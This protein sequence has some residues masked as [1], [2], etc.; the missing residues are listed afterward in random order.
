MSGEIE[1]STGPYYL[2]MG[3][4][5]DFGLEELKDM[6]VNAGLDNI[7]INNIPKITV[8]SGLNDIRLKEFP[9]EPL[10]MDSK[11]DMGLDDIRITQLPKIELET[12]VSI[13]PTR[14]HLPMNYKLSIGVMGYEL[15]GFA[16]CGE[17]MVIIEDYQ[18][19]ATEGCE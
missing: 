13:K 15:I 6:K 5:I 12:Q 10:K 8:D 3:G 16:L 11:V 19:H 18:K 14:V 7:R 17:G 2:T 4:G 1:I 9:K